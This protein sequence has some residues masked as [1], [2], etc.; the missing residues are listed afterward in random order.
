MDDGNYN[1]ETGGPSIAKIHAVIWRHAKKTVVI[2]NARVEGPSTAQRRFTD[3]SYKKALV[4]ISME[5]ERQLKIKLF[6]ENTQ[7]ID[8]SGARRF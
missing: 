4:I 3:F 8:Y 7:K 5:F 1:R 6:L 2:L